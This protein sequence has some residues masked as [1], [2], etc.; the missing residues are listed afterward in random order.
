MLSSLESDLFRAYGILPDLTLDQQEGDI[1]KSLLLLKLKTVMVSRVGMMLLRT[2]NLSHVEFWTIHITKTPRW[3]CK[4]INITTAYFRYRVK[5]HRKCQTIDPCHGAGKTTIVLKLQHIHPE[6]QTFFTKAWFE[7]FF[8]KKSITI[9][10]SHTQHLPL[11]AR[12]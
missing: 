6:L 9:I 8:S 1:Q 3:F 10:F 2:S 11:G 7:L 4:S 12:L 5:L